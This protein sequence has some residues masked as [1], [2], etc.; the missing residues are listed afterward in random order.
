MVAG[1]EQH[2]D[3]PLC[4]S[5]DQ[6]TQQRHRRAGGRAPVVHV[7]GDHYGLGPQL[8]GQG[9]KALCPDRLIG[10]FQQ[11]DAVDH[12]SQM[13]IGDMQYAHEQPSHFSTLYLK[14]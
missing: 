13:Q 2:G 14:L 5:L 7:P 8:V 11:G 9:E 4:Q 1:G 12:L 6:M 3:I 10:V